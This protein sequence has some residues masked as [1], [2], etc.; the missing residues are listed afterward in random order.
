MTGWKNVVPPVVQLPLPCEVFTVEWQRGRQIYGVPADATTFPALTQLPAD[1][2]REPGVP[3]V[4]AHEF[5][6]AHA[7]KEAGARRIFFDFDFHLN[8]DGQRLLGE[9][10]P[11]V[12]AKHL[13]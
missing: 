8:T 6:A 5:L 3:S 9:W 13:F 2:L 12:L 1:L 4:S 11:G 10:L 7:A